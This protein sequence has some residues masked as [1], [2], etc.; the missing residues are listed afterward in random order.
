MLLTAIVTAASL[1]LS[2]Q[3][4][5]QTTP[6]KIYQPT[7]VERPHTFAIGG[8][9]AVSNYGGSGGFRYFFNDRIGT[10]FTVG[11]SNGGPNSYGGGSTT[12]VMPSMVYMITPPNFTREADFRPYVGG[13]LH[14]VHGS[15]VST[16]P[17]TIP[18]PRNDW[19]YQA[20]GGLE[21]SFKSAKAFTISVEGIYYNV[22]SSPSGTTNHS[23]FDW[24]VSV[25]FYMK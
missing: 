8:S 25:H 12:F 10:N 19:G 24:T 1:A 11:W 4:Q 7:R 22:V 2:A 6:P 23:G 13:G 21:M 18:G 9:L 15:S 20:M 16:G 3:A 17:S 5:Q 14:Y